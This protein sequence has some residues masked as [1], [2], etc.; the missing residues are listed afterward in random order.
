MTE[1][2]LDQL[3]VG[4]QQQFG[5]VM[6]EL[7]LLRAQLKQA[8]DT[9]LRSQVTDVLAIA[10]TLDRA[11]AQSLT[12]MAAD[13]FYVNLG[14]V[15]GIGSLPA[16][17]TSA[18]VAYNTWDATDLRFYTNGAALNS[19]I[20]PSAAESRFIH[21]GG[22]GG[23]ATDYAPKNANVTKV[24]LE[25]RARF[26]TNGDNTV[27]GIGAKSV[28]NTS[29]NDGHF[30]QVTRNSAVWELGT[31]DGT[32]VSQSSGGTADGSFHNF[33]AEWD[34]AQV[35]LYVDGVSTITK[36]TN[37]PAQPLMAFPMY[38]DTTSSIDIVDYL[39]RWA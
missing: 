32:T 20:G 25:F 10:P 15:D 27:F 35:V 4:V 37:R 5:A 9:F 30:I 12:Y 14:L 18:S 16:W 23:T 24:I 29:F 31:R 17:L 38:A 1:I 26:N 33:K 2:T 22:F 7:E 36:T 8:R 6:N 3:S 39:V 11:D 28:A 21:Y 19:I 34:S 13:R